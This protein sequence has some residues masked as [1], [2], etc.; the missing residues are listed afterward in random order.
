[1]IGS[2][3]VPY[4][5]EDRISQKDFEKTLTKAIRNPAKK[6][7]LMSSQGRRHVLKNYNFDNFEKSW[8]NLIDGLIE[9]HGS[10]D[11]RKGHKRWHLLEVA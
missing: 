5:Y 2:L 6:Y 7:R 1:M 4:I 10:W 8:I 11:E 3:Q 9:E